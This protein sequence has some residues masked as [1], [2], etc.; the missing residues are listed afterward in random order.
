MRIVCSARRS[1]HRRLAAALI[2]VAVVV[3]LGYVVATPGYT[4]IHDDH[5]YDRLAVAVASTGA[6]PLDNGRPTA[7][8][9]P[10]Y[11]YVLGGLYALTGARGHADTTAS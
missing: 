9:P 1:R 2:A 4:P 3:R 7:Y 8:R 6:Y 10:G 5:A 11:P